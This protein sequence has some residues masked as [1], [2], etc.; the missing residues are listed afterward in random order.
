MPDRRAT[1]LAAAAELFA[2]KGVAGAGIDEIGALAGV[3]GPA[4]YRHFRGKDALVRAVILQGLAAF[5]LPEGAIADGLGAMSRHAAIAALDAPAFLVTYL[6]ERHR[7]DGEA[8]DELLE[9]ERQLFRPWRDTMLDL[10][11]SLDADELAR[12]HRAV[13]TAVGATA[14]RGSKTPRAR[15]EDLLVDSMVA[16]L[17][18]PPLPTRPPPAP[19]PT[20]SV[21]PGRRD[22]ILAAAM[23]LFRQRGFHGVSMDDIGTATGI[24]GPTI[25]FHYES[26]LDVLVEAHERASIRTWVAVQDAVRDAESAADAL[27]RLAAAQLAVAAQNSDLILVTSREIA[28]PDAA[29]RERLEQRAADIVDI[30][31]AVLGELRSELGRSELR[32][33]LTGVFPLMNQ[34]AYLLARPEDGIALVRAWAQGGTPAA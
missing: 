7:L 4:I 5:E 6:R 30:W 10:Q 31:T 29:D 28:M 3:T 17:S 19:A 32:A 1:I 9:L 2:Q 13:F 27:D 15:R 8:R 23:T 24:T 33:V 22:Q 26:K 25:Y 34:T 21:P 20:W 16:V 14:S 12:R 11:P 18:L